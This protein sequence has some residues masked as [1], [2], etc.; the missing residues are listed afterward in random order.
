MA[1]KYDDITVGEVFEK[2]RKVTDEMIREFAKITGDDNPVHLDEEYAKNTIFGGRIAHGILILGLV[3]A[4]L[5]RDFPGP[6]T[7]YLKQDAKFKRPVYL[8]EEI[9]IRVEVLEKITGKS[10]IRL[11][12]QVIKSNGEIAVDGEALVMFRDK[13]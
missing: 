10:R 4:V 11:S 9:T 2:K 13:S 7:I 5:G 6:G 8:D 3:S 1:R 12:T